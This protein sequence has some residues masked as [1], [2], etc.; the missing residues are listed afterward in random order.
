MGQSV[1]TNTTTVGRP[2]LNNWAGW[3]P[4]FATAC[5]ANTAANNDCTSTRLQQE[6]DRLIEQILLPAVVALGQQPHQV[7]AGM[8]AERPRCTRQLHPGFIRRAAA[9]AVIAW[10][11]ARDEIFPRR[12]S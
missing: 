1:R 11:T 12:L 8:Q 6:A 5:K 2:F 4:R 10:V 3:P 7:P 9:L